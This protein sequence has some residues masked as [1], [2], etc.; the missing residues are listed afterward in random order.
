MIKFV[1]FNAETYDMNRIIEYP[2]FNVPT[3]PGTVDVSNICLHISFRKI[4]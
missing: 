2:G 1:V 4:H 3:P